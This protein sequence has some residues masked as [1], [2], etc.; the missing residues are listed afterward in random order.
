MRNRVYGIIGIK[1]S[2]S[3]WNADFTG[4]PKTLGNGEI[5]GSDKAVKYPMRQLWRNQGDKVFSIRTFKQTEEK[6]NNSIKKLH[7]KSLSERYTELFNE[8]ARRQ[9]TTTV[10]KNLFS[11]VDIMNFGVTFAEAGQNISITGSVQIMQ[12]INKYKNSQI[13]VGDI[14]CPFRNSKSDEAEATTLGTTV[15]TDEA[16]YFYS[17]VV[18]P[19]NYE[20]YIGLIEGFEGYTTDAYE[21]FKTASRISATVYNSVSKV[22][23]ENEFALFVECKCGEDA[24]LPEL[25]QFVLFSKGEEKC[26]IDITNLSFLNQN[27]IRSAIEQ[28]EIYYN[29]YT[30]EIKESIQA[31]KY[32]IFTKEEY[33]EST[34]V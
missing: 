27:K 6:D 30:T 1:S 9:S 8:D 19:G 21:K 13:I 15:L 4:R 11:T 2:M 22:G 32:N 10:L 14:M 3:N 31:K 23:C 12:G 29:P 28:V 16:H 20:D 25:A 24:Y 17:F 26:C 18:N 5:Y 33:R 34:Y 7:P